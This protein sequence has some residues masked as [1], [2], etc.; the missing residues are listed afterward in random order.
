MKRFSYGL[1]C[2]ALL[3]ASLP[4]LSMAAGTSPQAPERTLQQELRALR[5]E[6]SPAQRASL[7]AVLPC[8]LYTSDAADE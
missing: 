7:A 8:L 3:T 2:A 4:A 1:C 5:G 6:L